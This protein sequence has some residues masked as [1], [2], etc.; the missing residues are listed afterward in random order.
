MLMA[1]F[2]IY[3]SSPLSHFTVL[4]LSTIEDEAITIEYISSESN[5]SSSVDFC[6][7]LRLFIRAAV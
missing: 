7:P 1:S 3:N 2:D 4:R 5:Q 6:S